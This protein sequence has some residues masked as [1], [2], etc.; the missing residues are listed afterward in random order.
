MSSTATNI[1]AA[2]NQAA[3]ANNQ[4]QLQLTPDDI[5]W[6]RDIFNKMMICNQNTKNWTSKMIQI[7]KLTE[8]MAVLETKAPKQKI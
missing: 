5:T 3:F 2:Y 1:A 4:S 8:A 6:N 7:I